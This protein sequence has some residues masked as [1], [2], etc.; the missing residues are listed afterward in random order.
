[1]IGGLLM[2]GLHGMTGLG[3]RLGLRG[4]GM[5]LV[6]PALLA[7]RRH[8]LCSQRRPELRFRFLRFLTLRLETKVLQLR[9]QQFWLSPQDFKRVRSQDRVLA[10]LGVQS[11]Q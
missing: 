2:T 11:L 6:S 9:S 3:L 1:M 8:Q 5:K 7:L 4:L 10:L